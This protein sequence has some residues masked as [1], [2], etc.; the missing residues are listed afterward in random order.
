LHPGNR[1]KPINNEPQDAED[2]KGR[3]AE[4]AKNFKPGNVGGHLVGGDEGMEGVTDTLSNI[5][6]PSLQL[7]LIGTG[8]LSV[9]YGSTLTTASLSPIYKGYIVTPGQH[10]SSV[11]VAGTT[12][13]AT[14]TSVH[15]A[16][17]LQVAVP[18]S[19]MTAPSMQVQVPSAVMTVPSMQVQV[20]SDVMTVPSSQ[21]NVPSSAMNSLDLQPALCGR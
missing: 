14:P 7:P 9:E 5:Q 10:G 17:S 13:I 21:I 1:P 2:R 8:D 4:I 18:T 3:S 19:V 12:Q 15:T 11:I 6:L 16:P 20:P